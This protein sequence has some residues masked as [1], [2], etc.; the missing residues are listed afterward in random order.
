MCRIVLYRL[1]NDEICI[2][3]ET[4]RSGQE[5][6]IMERA[7]CPHYD[8][9]HGRQIRLDG[10]DPGYLVEVVPVERNVTPEL[11]IF[12][13]FAGIA[14]E[15]RARLADGNGKG[16]VIDAVCSGF[17]KP[18]IAALLARKSI[19]PRIMLEMLASMTSKRHDIEEATWI[20]QAMQVV[21]GYPVHAYFT[22]AGFVRPNGFFDFP[23]SS[24]LSYV[25]WLVSGGVNGDRFQPG[26]LPG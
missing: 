8:L 26:R 19:A 20:R 4:L 21:A 2:A 7:T 23:S 15:A 25:V 10:L 13:I 5:L 18:R 9:L 3:L 12:D 22:K 14:Q 1:D 17:L 6:N 11:A 16:D 24:A